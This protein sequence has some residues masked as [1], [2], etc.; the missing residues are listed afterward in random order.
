MIRVLLAVM[1]LV[2]AGAFAQVFKWVDAEGRTQF[3]DRPQQDAETVGLK[4]V[5]PAPAE[6]VTPVGDPLKSAPKLG[7]YSAF[8]IM[9]PEPNQTLRQA[10]DTVPVSLL[11]TPPLMEGHHLELMFDG[12]PISVAA[13]AGTQFSLTGVT[14]GSHQAYAQVR[15]PQ[16]ALVAATAVVTFHLRK[17]IPPGVLP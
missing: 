3:S 5:Q 2:S 9:S 11:V 14:F 8:E 6:A 1:M 15:D 12:V 4:G 17:P 7:P 10:Q 13:S 16:N